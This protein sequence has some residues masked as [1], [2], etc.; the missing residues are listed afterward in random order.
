MLDDVLVRLVAAASVH[1]ETT[2]KRRTTPTPRD[3]AGLFEVGTRQGCEYVAL[4]HLL[5]ADN[6]DLNRVSNRGYQPAKTAPRFRPH[7]G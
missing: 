4:N 6:I 7:C 1:G 2:P 3:S 5:D